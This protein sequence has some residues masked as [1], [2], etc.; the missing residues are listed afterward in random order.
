MQGGKVSPTIQHT[1]LFTNRVNVKDIN[2]SLNA[3]GNGLITCSLIL[4]ENNEEERFSNLIFK[5]IQ[6]EDCEKESRYI[7]I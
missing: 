5:S 3:T 7:K 1:H 4:W 6:I 2:I